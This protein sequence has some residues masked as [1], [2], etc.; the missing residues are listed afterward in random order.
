MNRILFLFFCLVLL[1]LSPGL[2]G[3]ERPKVGLVLSGGGAKGLAHIGVLK[4]L[5]EAG[6]RPDYITGTSMGSII[7]GL[8]A[9]G[10]S[11]HE[12]DSIVTSVNWA[13][14]LSDRI[15]LS[16]V[17][18]EEKY[19]YCRFD[20]EL[21][22]SLECLS[23]PAGL[24]CGQ[25]ISE[26]LS[27]LSSGVA[28]V[29]SFSD[30]PIPF[31]CV[32][33][34]LLSGEQVV[35]NSGSFTT[36]LRASMSISFVFAPVALDSMLLIDGGVLNNFPVQLCMDMGADI[37]IGVNVGTAD[38]AEMSDL[39]SPVAVLAASAMIGNS[40]SFRQQVPFV[41]VLIEP[42][43]HPYSTASF[44]HGP[45]IIALG[46]EAARLQM[47]TLHGLAQR[48]DSLGEQT[49]KPFPPRPETYLI[50]SITL[51][52]G[53]HIS[54]RFF[55]SSLGIAPGDTVKNEDLKKGMN[56]LMGTRY[57]ESV[58]YDLKPLRE[59]YALTVHATESARSRFKFSLHYDNENK[60]GILTNL[61]L[62]NVL[63]RGNR[64]A[65][66]LDVSERPRLNLSFINYYGENHRTASRLEGVWE[67]SNFPVYLEDGAEYG[68][69]T[70]NLTN[71]SLGF[72]SSLD[73]RWEL[74]GF[75]ALERSV[76]KQQ[77]GLYE[78]FASGVDRFGNQLLSANFTANRNTY[79]R[80]F[81]PTR[82]NEF[83][84]RYRFYLDNRK[85]YRG[86]E[87]VRDVVEPA[88]ARSAVRFFELSGSWQGVFLLGS[89]F[90]VSPRIQASYA[91]RPLPL[92]AMNFIGGMPF[93]RRTR[94]VSFVG[95]SSREKTVQDFAMAQINV[96][97]RFS[98]SM[99]LTGVVN[100]LA[101][102][103]DSEAIYRPVVM[104]DEEYI[105]GYGLIMEMDSFLGPVQVG[106]S[107]SNVPGGLRWYIGLG[108]PF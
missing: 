38:K 34:D 81:F 57:F 65:A 2:R 32:A 58:A 28:G 83:V 62:R 48:L 104:E 60:A 18:P 36:A 86:S 87:S 24:V 16:D 78:V 92:M 107:D 5:E 59:G 95:L 51:E 23:V 47:E 90:A 96:R 41:D 82:G 54:H 74:N 69:F 79:N 91:N 72:M 37:I 66:T 76:L 108:Y 103:S 44:F 45:Q 9:I 8:Y 22:L 10:Y 101:A 89:R 25:S 67:N 31:Q 29:H 39:N 73:T 97:Y 93:Q 7:G 100:G 77:S 15:P 99:H 33:A 17:I 63:L 30:Y 4:A 6:I 14:L 1:L 56:R 80:R 88:I 68:R 13:Q 11:A 26:L 52:G 43:L 55:M 106:V 27:R 105:L 64:L 70:H 50:S 12:L 102:A 3:Q 35:F 40:L 20:G 19:D 61:T 75:M 46:E 71:L 42:E 49:Q 85:V 94:E 21:N 84:F 53:E 98:R